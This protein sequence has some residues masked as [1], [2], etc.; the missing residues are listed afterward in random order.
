MECTE[1]CTAQKSEQGTHFRQGHASSP[2]S[3]QTCRRANKKPP[4]AVFRL[5]HSGGLEP[6]TIIW[7]APRVYCNRIGQE[8]QC[9]PPKV[10]NCGG[11]FFCSSI[12]S[13]GFSFGKALI[14]WIECAHAPC[15]ICRRQ[16]SAVLPRPPTTFPSPKGPAAQK[17]TALPVDETGKAVF[18]V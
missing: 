7:A 3:G 6:P 4:P 8:N 15:F 9:S 17:E 12:R 11:F 18:L 16:R 1:Y 14:D 13:R 10:Q 2:P 5:T